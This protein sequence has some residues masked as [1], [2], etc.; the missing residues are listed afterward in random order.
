MRFMFFFL[1][2]VVGSTLLALIH[3]YL[4]IRLVRDPALS[5]PW[6]FILT[7][8]LVAFA[9]SLPMAMTISRWAPFSIT[10]Y[11]VWLPYVW[12]GTMLYFLFF[13]GAVD[14]LRGMAWVAGKISGQAALTDGFIQSLMFKRLLAIGVALIALGLSVTSVC[15]GARSEQVDRIEIHLDRLPTSF[16]GLTI[17]Q[18]SDL[19]VGLTRA[20]D[21]IDDLADKVNALNADIIVITGDLMD[22]PPERLAGELKGLAKLKAP[23]GVYF[24]TG[25]H[26]YYSGA[27][28][29]MPELEKLGMRVLRNERVEIRRNGA[30]FDMAGIDDHNAEGMAEGHGANLDGALKGRD[31]DREVILLAH[32]PRAGLQAAKLDVGLVL[33][34]HTHGGQIWPFSCLVR[35]QQP[36]LKGL[37]RIPDSRT[38]V[39][40][41]QGTW[42]WGPPMRLGSHN[43]I[44]LITL[45]SAKPIVEN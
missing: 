40:V 16:D 39:Y 14:T 35:L 7:W 41:N 6:R 18:I 33:S 2:I 38:Q 20:G 15:L 29:W 43:E 42:T 19:H 4:W 34:G 31:P 13:L 36:Y 17:A 3:Y 28:E 27:P 24:V 30:V 23:L 21:W 11:L 9:A 8:T 10:Q 26:E 1:W 12:M 45:T 32:Q 44:S 22:G 37:H 25:N 5:T